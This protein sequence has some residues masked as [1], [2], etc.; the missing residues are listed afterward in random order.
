MWL[1]IKEEQLTH[2]WSVLL[3]AGNT[4]PTYT[5]DNINLSG[6]W[7]IG[8]LTICDEG[9]GPEVIH[10]FPDKDNFIIIFIVMSNKSPLVKDL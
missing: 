9:I 3:M 2:G 10:V 5:G 8:P 4:L 6:I 1:K 7:P